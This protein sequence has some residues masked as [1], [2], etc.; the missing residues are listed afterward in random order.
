M[1]SFQSAASPDPNAY[2]PSSLDSLP[3]PPPPP[4]PPRSPTSSHSLPWRFI[5]T[6]ATTGTIDDRDFILK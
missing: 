6:D 4:P 1:S 3:P 2:L 5:Q